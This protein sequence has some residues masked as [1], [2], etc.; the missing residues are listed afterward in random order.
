MVRHPLQQVGNEPGGVAEIG[1]EVEQVIEMMVD[2]EPDRRQGRRAQ[3]QLAR[4]VQHVDV[5]QS[6]AQ[7]SSAIWPVPS[8][9]LSSI[10]RIEQSGANWRIVSTSGLRLP[11]SL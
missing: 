10:T 7:I 6:I 5:W 9:E 11:A 1:V 4:P 3:P 8:G 2:R